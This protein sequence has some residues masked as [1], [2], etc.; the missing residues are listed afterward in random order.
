[1]A[2]S[3]KCPG[4]W[5]IAAAMF[6]KKSFLPISLSY[7]FIPVLL[8]KSQRNSKPVRG[9]PSPK[10]PLRSQPA[11][12]YRSKVLA[13]G[14]GCI[15][16]RLMRRMRFLVPQTGHLH[17]FDDAAIVC[18]FEAK[19]I[20]GFSVLIELGV[21]CQFWKEGSVLHL[22]ALEIELAFE[23]ANFNDKNFFPGICSV[24]N[25]RNGLE[26]HQKGSKST[27]FHCIIVISRAHNRAQHLLGPHPLTAHECRFQLIYTR[28]SRSTV[29]PFSREFFIQ[30]EFDFHFDAKQDFS[31][32]SSVWKSFAQM[33]QSWSLE[34]EWRENS[35]GENSG[36][37][38]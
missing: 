24:R 34:L 8:Y 35:C 3:V 17:R 37:A 25:E 6:L 20:T 28:D 19:N 32:M 15:W 33:G 38:L 16:R 9:T 21:R 31:R 18:L 7:I 29:G 13:A 5:F 11:R 10:R 36:E 23:R 12:L 26:K 30:R 1:M 2:N 27:F 22:L 4:V 14:D